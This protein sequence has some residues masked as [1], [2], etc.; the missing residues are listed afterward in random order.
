MYQEKR[1]IKGVSISA[2]KIQYLPFKMAPA[3]IMED[4]SPRWPPLQSMMATSLNQ[5]KKMDASQIA[6][7]HLLNDRCLGCFSSSI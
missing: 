6:I 4:S 7:G 1:L 5:F 3:K 2:F